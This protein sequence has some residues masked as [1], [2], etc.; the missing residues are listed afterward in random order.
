VDETI[1]T[2]QNA[3]QLGNAISI[4]VYGSG[5]QTQLAADNANTLRPNNPV[6]GQ[7]R[8]PIGPFNLSC[9]KH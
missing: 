6:K 2:A 4:Q 3:M 5:I 7:N 9:D 1:Q 8:Y